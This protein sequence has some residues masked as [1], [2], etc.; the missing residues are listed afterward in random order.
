MTYYSGF[1]LAVPDANRQAYISHARKTWPMFKKHGALRM[2]E[3][4]GD[5]VPKG[6]VTDFYRAVQAVP[7]ESVVFSW[8]EWPDRETSDLGWQKIMEEMPQSDMG[9][10]PFDG[11]RMIWGGFT[12]VY[13]SDQD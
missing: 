2:V 6:K 11:Q 12:P 13:D 3:T 7:G 4:W 10:M 8:I 1:V 9:E 5:D